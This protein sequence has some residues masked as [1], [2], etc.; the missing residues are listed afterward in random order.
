[1]FQKIN[2]EELPELMNLLNRVF[3]E[4]EIRTD[5]DIIR[6][7]ERGRMKAYGYR[8]KGKLTAGALGYETEDFFLLE[9][10]AADPAVRGRGYG[11]MIM[12]GLK[13]E[14]PSLILEVEVPEDAVAKR[15]VHFYEKHGLELSEQPYVM[16]PLQKGNLPTPYCLMSYNYDVEPSTVQDIYTNVYRRD[17]TLEKLQEQLEQ[18]LLAI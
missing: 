3:D 5:E 4:H 16:P 9:N 1:M 7:Y 15:R 10:L 13:E 12:E 11:G 6:F 17:T 8:V 2:R 14:F 18:G